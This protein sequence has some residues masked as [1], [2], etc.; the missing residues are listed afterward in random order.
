MTMNTMELDGYTAVIRYN[1]ET[2]EFRAYSIASSPLQKNIIELVVRLVPAGLCS[3]Y[4]HEALEVGVGGGFIR[5]FH[6]WR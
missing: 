2:D 4:I 6:G 3:T 1:P 5:W